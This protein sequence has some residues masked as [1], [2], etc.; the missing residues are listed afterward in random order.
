MNL[1]FKLFLL[2]GILFATIASSEASNWVN[3]FYTDDSAYYQKVYND[4]FELRF[5]VHKSHCYEVT[6]ASIQFNSSVL[7]NTQIFTALNDLSAW[8]KIYGLNEKDWCWFSTRIRGLDH[9]QIEQ[10]KYVLKFEDRSGEVLYFQ[11]PTDSILPRSRFARNIKQWMTPAPLGATPVIGGG[12]LFKLWEPVAD[13]VHLF[14]NERRMHVM[15]ADLAKGHANR[16]HHYF[17]PAA[18]MSDRYHFQYLKDGRYEELE[19]SNSKLMSPVKIDPMAREITYDRKGGSLNA[20]LNPRAV[21][22]QL[23]PPRTW[24]NDRHIRNQSQLEYQNWILYQLWP[25]AFNPQKRNGRYQVGRFTDIAPKLN[26]LESLGVSAVEF[27]PV[28]ESR[29][30]ASWGYAMDS[31][32]LIEKSYGTREEL[33][34][35]I[36]SIHG[37]RMKVV[38]DVVINH[39]NNYLIRDPLTKNQKR[40]KY[41]GGDTEWGPKPD[42]ENI[43]VKK[44]IADSLLNLARDYHIDGFRFDMIEHVYHNSAAGYRFVQE[45]NILLKSENPY[46]YSSAEQLP[47]NVWVTYPIR[48]NGLGFDSQWSDKFKN[49]FE[50]EFDHYRPGNLKLDTSPLVGTLVGF[51]NH[52]N[53][54]GEYPFGHPSRVVNYLGSHDVVGNKNPILRIVS[55]FE[56]FESVNGKPFYRVRPLE[57]TI[58]TQARF[59]QVHNPFTHSVGKLGYGILFSS[60]GAAL[61]YQG[62][63]FAQDINIENEW[64]YLFAR[65]GNTIPTRDVD[66]HRY[67]GSHRVPW[68]Y[69]E[70]EKSPEL[71]FLSREEHRLFKGYHSFIKKMIH[72]KK[73]YPEINLQHAQ[74]VREYGDGIVTFKLNAG[75]ET[76]FVVLNFGDKRA[77]QWITFPGST[78]N[79]WQEVLTTASPEFGSSQGNYQNIIPQLG[80]RN[81]QLRLEATSFSIFVERSR[82]QFSQNLYLMS[83]LTN[84]RAD[85]R[86]KLVPIGDAGNLFSTTITLDLSTDFEFKFAT[87]DWIIDIGHFASSKSPLN[88]SEQLSYT[89]KLPNAKIHLKA[90]KYRL[91]FDIKTFK[92]SFV[93]Y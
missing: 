90:G 21:V 73:A 12:V 43:M 92:Y 59:R 3:S 57:E 24:V 84:W 82:P 18:R 20:Y 29:F 78:R 65:D 25:L 60:P 79:W 16:V 80:G 48:D 86:Y 52:R 15:T 26:Y 83:P 76:F 5:R 35:L 22:A 38:L 53:W 88:T 37:K 27:L 17:D 61:F 54:E 23:I 56:S 46:F 36:D 9:S 55:D 33:A 58:N 50:L 19:V 44:W 62:E 87:Q 63:E 11:A 85:E 30:N 89:P 40:T 67:V 13:Q 75:R 70:T 81:N 69:L 1:L 10:N 91:I 34:W 74:E 39:L 2:P 8:P 66:I 71:S 41:F 49:F 45:L 68:E 47:D 72:F 93:A 7:S 64:T 14:I 31:L 32:T 4:G 51:S 77:D 28:H 42:F 6:R